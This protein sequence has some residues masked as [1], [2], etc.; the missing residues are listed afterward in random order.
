MYLY[1]TSHKIFRLWRNRYML[2]NKACMR[3]NVWCF[4][5][6]ALNFFTHKKPTDCMY[7]Y[8]HCA[9]RNRHFVFCVLFFFVTSVVVALGCKEIV[10]IFSEFSSAISVSISF[11]F[12]PSL[13]FFHSHSLVI[14]MMSVA[15]KF[16]AKTFFL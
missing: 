12:R 14:R 10:I 16:M 9:K 7:V 13:F 5:L 4:R 8:V 1:G 3:T 15:Q 6:S 11:S 2:E